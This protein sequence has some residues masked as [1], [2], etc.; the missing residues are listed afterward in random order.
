MK[1]NTPDLFDYRVVQALVQGGSFRAAAD[2]L[3]MSPSALSR[4]VAALESRLG[5]RLFDRDTR[6]VAPTTSGQALA[7]LA[8]RMLNTAEDVRA[9]FDAHLS[10]SRGRLT[11]AGLPSVT[12]GLLPGLLASFTRDHP[13]IDLRILDALSGSV[14]EAIEAGRADI[15]FTAGTVTARMRLAFQPLLDDPFVAVGAPTGPLAEPRTYT[16]AELTRLPF[17]AMELGT[18]V[19][20]LLDGACQR[21]GTTLAPR[22]EAAHLATAGA[23]VAEG[24]G[25]TILPRLTLPVLPMDRLVERQIA[26]F[27][28]KRRIG[29]VRQSGRSLS[30][31]AT[32]F[33]DHVRRNLAPS[34]P[35]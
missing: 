12:A 29:L 1:H 15:G 22:F 2:V 32:A 9:E 4:H 17:I 26:D 24:M 27:G 5:C 25:I 13:D 10:A 16:M 33:L 6:N 34:L 8:E 31:A 28:A 35:L 21:I 11:I 20:E 14:V 23:L 30:P 19:R 7:R 18:S 3:G